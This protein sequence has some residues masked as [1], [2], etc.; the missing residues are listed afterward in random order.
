MNYLH[1]CGS[2]GGRVLA[3]RG[4]HNGCLHV[5]L[6][7]GIQPSHAPTGCCYDVT[8]LTVTAVVLTRMH[9]TDAVD[10]ADVLYLL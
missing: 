8:G 9:F 7:I 5:A 3:Y 1:I 10:E 6:T 2:V 4:L